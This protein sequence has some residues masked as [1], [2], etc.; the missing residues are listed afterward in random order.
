M[1]DFNFWKSAKNYDFRYGFEHNQKALYNLNNTICKYS[2]DS[3]QSWCPTAIKNDS[4][5]LLLLIL[6][7][8]EQE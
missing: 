1:L 8:N 3:L 7:L 4:H 6:K 5:L 2:S